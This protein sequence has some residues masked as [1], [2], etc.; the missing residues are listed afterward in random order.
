MFQ[1]TAQD[2]AEDPYCRR[3]GAL[4]RSW[5][6]TAFLLLHCS[7]CTGA[8]PN[9][10]PEDA[11]QMVHEGGV[12]LDVRSRA[13]FEMGHLPGALWMPAKRADEYVGE[14]RAIEGPIVVYCL[15]GH[16]SDSVVQQLRAAGFEEV[17]DLASIMRWPSQ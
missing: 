14:L 3:A 8:V 16:R 1:F 4:R 10:A 5:M 7:G 6:A 13:E 12:L 17:Y 11:L 9:I 2:R 15:S